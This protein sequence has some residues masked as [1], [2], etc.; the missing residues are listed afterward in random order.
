MLQQY[1]EISLFLL[2][3]KFEQTIKTETNSYMLNT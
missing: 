2:K 3:V 1:Q